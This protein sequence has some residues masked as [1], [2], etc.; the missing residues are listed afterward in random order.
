MNVSAIADFH[1]EWVIFKNF[2]KIA[3]ALRW[4]QFERIFKFY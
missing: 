4:E 3:L 2:L 1:Y